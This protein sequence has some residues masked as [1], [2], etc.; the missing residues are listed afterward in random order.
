MQQVSLDALA[1]TQVNLTES[2]TTPASTGIP[3]DVQAADFERVLAQAHEE[4]AEVQF[5]NRPQSIAQI[6]VDRVTMPLGEMSDRYT[7]TANDVQVALKNFD[8][9][10][11]ES[12]KTVVGNLSDLAVQGAL[13]HVAVNEI[14]STRKS[15]QDLFQ[16]QG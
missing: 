2:V 4:Q 15:L 8:V 12:F 3:S 11:P 14:T 7:R 13:F 10:N 5:V 16:N 6:G 1:A 9:G